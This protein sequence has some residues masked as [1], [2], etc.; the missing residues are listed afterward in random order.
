MICLPLSLPLQHSCWSPALLRLLKGSLWAALAIY[1]LLFVVFF[2]GL[3]LLAS[4]DPD[5]RW[6]I[7]LKKLSRVLG[8]QSTLTQV[9][10]SECVPVPLGRVPFTCAKH[11]ANARACTRHNYLLLSVCVCV[12]VARAH[13]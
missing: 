2:T 4:Y 3:N 10:D 1:T 9:V 7:R 13:S 11:P 6:Q 8:C 5:K 12:Y